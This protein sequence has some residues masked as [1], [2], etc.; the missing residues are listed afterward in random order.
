MSLRV[1]GTDQVTTNTLWRQ[2]RLAQ[3]T[4]AP[5]RGSEI[6][7]NV[8]SWGKLLRRVKTLHQKQQFSANLTLYRL[9]QTA[10]KFA[11][12]PCPVSETT[13]LVTGLSGGE[14]E[15]PAPRG[16]SQPSRPPAGRNSPLTPGLTHNQTKRK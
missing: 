14:V 1:P 2:S 8:T 15:G 11:Y 12:L 16:R 3:V 13:G 5:S 9:G 4:P 6:L 10:I 7:H